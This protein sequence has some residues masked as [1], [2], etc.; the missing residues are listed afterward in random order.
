MQKEEKN[1][2]RQMIQMMFLC[3]LDSWA[4]FCGQ[5]GFERNCERVEKKKKR[6]DDKQS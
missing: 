5:K 6:L 1:V 3:A 2:T 4:D